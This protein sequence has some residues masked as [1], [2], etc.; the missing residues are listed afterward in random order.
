MASELLSRTGRGFY[1]DP[2]FRRSE[3]MLRSR[4]GPQLADL[5]YRLRRRGLGEADVARATA[6]AEIG[7]QN[8]FGNLVSEHM[9]YLQARREAKRDRRRRFWGGLLGLAGELVPGMRVARALGRAASRVDTSP[10]YAQPTGYPEEDK[11]GLATRALYPL[12]Y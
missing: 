8:I 10:S 3:V 11:R 1:L 12:G 4:V 2:D 7:A 5:K 6:G 9:S